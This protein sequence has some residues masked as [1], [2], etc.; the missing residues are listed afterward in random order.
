MSYRIGR[1]AQL[2][3]FDQ[4]VLR[5]WERRYGLLEPERT[6]NGYRLYTDDDL[7][8]LKRVRELL[9]QGFH[10]GEIV[11]MGRARLV[12]RD[13]PAHGHDQTGIVPSEVFVQAVDSRRADVAWSILDALPCA[14]IVTDKQGRVRWVNRGVPVLCGYDLPELHGRTPGEMLQGPD[15]DPVAIERLRKSI[16]EQRPCSVKVLNY[17]KSGEPYSALVDVAPLGV[18]AQHVGYVGIARRINAVT[19]RPPPASDKT[20]RAKPRRRRSS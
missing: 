19:A 13:A 4:T 20:P 10:I 17:H 9:D 15:S 7:A 14:V 8:L 11:R 5:A 2:S 1:L 3:G 18:G 6:G 16:A 12:E